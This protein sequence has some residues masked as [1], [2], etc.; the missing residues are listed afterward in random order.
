MIISMQR[1][2]IVNHL[3]HRW[4]IIHNFEI[5]ELRTTSLKDRFNL[6]S[7]VFNSTKNLKLSAQKPDFEDYAI[8]RKWLRLKKYYC[9]PK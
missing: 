6:T 7:V 9:E 3:K 2:E 1:K 4:E 8:M 5:E